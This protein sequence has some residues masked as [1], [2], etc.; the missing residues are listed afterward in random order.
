[1]LISCVEDSF[2][3][4]CRYFHL[5]S[6]S[7]YSFPLVYKYLCSETGCRNNFVTYLCTFCINCLCN[8]PNKKKEEDS[9]LRGIRLRLRTPY[10]RPPLIRTVVIRFSNYPD[11]FN[12]SNKH[13]LTVIVLYILW[14]KFFPPTV[15]YIKGII[16]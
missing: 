3:F 7:Y 2:I 13:F 11:R 6:Q 5:Y 15:K 9:C 8:K 12:P 4:H 10:S 16:Y 14:F 1:M